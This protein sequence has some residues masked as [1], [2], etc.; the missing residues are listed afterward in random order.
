[1]NTDKPDA[2]LLPCPFCGSQNVRVEWWLDDIPGKQEED[3]GIGRNGPTNAE[4]HIECDGCRFASDSYMTA[5]VIV[6]KWNARDAAERDALLREVEAARRRGGW[7]YCEDAFP[8]KPDEYLITYISIYDGKPASGVA[9]YVR[10]EW[11][12]DDGDVF[13]VPVIAWRPLPEPAEIKRSE[14]EV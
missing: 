9:E 10:D 2:E 12:Y 3:Y 13:T 6:D 1:M 7:T 4:Y 11:R 8:T 5:Q 14:D